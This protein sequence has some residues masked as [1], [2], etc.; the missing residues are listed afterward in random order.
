[1]WSPS[2]P[3]FFSFATC[4]NSRAKWEESAGVRLAT[5]ESLRKFSFIAKL[6]LP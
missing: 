2:S 5:P 1:M 3:W 6:K 4:R